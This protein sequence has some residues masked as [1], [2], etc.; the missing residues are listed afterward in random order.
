MYNLEISMAFIITELVYICLRASWRTPP[1]AGISRYIEDLLV[2]FCCCVFF[3]GRVVVSLAHSPFLFSILSLWP[4]N[5]MNRYQTM[6]TRP[7]CQSTHTLSSLY[8]KNRPTLVYRLPLLLKSVKSNWTLSLTIINEKGLNP[9]YK[10]ILLPL[11]MF[12]YC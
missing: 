3:Y 7:T 11:S 10:K 5:R 9:T 4:P 12:N 8:K 6:S 2:T 1:G